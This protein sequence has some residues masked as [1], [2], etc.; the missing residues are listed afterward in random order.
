MEL[1]NRSFP[2]RMDCTNGANSEDL[3]YVAISVAASGGRSTAGGA[4]EGECG[5]GIRSI[6][7]IVGGVAYFDGGVLSEMQRAW[8]G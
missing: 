4:D 6:G 5:G 2:E 1:S 8:T 3:R 7:G